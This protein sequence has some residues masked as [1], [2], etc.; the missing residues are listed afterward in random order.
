AGGRGGYP[1]T[2]GRALALLLIS[3]IESTTQAE[4]AERLQVSHASVSPALRFLVETGMVDRVSV[5]GMR[6]GRFKLRDQAWSTFAHSISLTLNIYVDL[7]ER[8]IR[9]PGPQLSP[10]RNQLRRLTEIF[11]AYRAV[12]AEAATRS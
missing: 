8:G 6:S 9:I 1:R 2:A 3:D 12:M 11:R 7:F 5:P 4:L 10:G